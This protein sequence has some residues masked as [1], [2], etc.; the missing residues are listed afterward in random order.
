MGNP[1][2]TAIIAAGGRGLRIGGARP[3]QFV[4]L[5]GRPM[6]WHTLEPFSKSGFIDRIVLVVPEADI[7]YCQERFGSVFAKLQKIVAAGEERH[8]SVAAGLA[9]TG[10]GDEY[11]IVHDGAR[12]LVSTD[13]I[14]RVVVETIAHGAAIAAT[15]AK[16]TI[17]VIDGSFVKSTPDRET[18]WC[19]QTPQGFKRQLLIEAT[20]ARDPKLVPTD[21]A[22]LIEQFGAPVRVVAGE[23]TNIKITTPPDL[24][25]AERLLQMRDNSFI[26]NDVR[27]GNGYDVHRFAGGRKLMLG[28]VHVPWDEGLSGHSDADVLTHAIIDALLGA[29][30]LGDIGRLFP[31]T[32]PDFAGISS[33][34]LLS[35]VGERLAQQGLRIG[36]IDAVVM[37]EQ[38]KLA[39][40]IDEMEEVLAATLDISPTRVSVKATTTEGLGFVGRREGIAVQSVAF[41]TS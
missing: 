21:E 26:H 34:T 7:E 24:L 30:G 22:T 40:H 6:L 17:K 13:L 9:A 8:Q 29:A 33:L 16:E 4:T 25:W 12:P 27:I 3:K 1:T 23:D 36:N 20:S 32:N 15:A 2:A 31:D 19:A 39:A 28:G 35:Q 37:A 41:L 11:V 10:V 18:L 38:P 5:A 14:Q